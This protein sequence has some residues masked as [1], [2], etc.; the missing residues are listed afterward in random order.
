MPKIL[1]EPSRAAQQDW[2]LRLVIKKGGWGGE[3]FFL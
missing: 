1:G 2:S 3:V